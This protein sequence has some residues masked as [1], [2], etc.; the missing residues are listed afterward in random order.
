MSSWVG[1]GSCRHLFR[2]ELALGKTWFDVEMKQ[3]DPWRPTGLDDL[4]PAK[5]DERYPS[6]LRVNIAAA[7]RLTDPIQTDELVRR[8]IDI[9]WMCWIQ[10]HFENR[11][12]KSEIK[13]D[14]SSLERR[15][16]GVLAKVGS[17]E[18]DTRRV[19]KLV[20]DREPDDPGRDPPREAFEVRVEGRA[21]GGFGDVRVAEV[22]SQL[23]LLISWCQR[24]R[25]ILGPVGKGRPRQE[26][27]RQAVQQLEKIWT[28]VTGSPPTLRYNPWTKRS[29]GP[30]LDFVTL[31]LSPI[32]PEVERHI[33]WEAFVREAI[34]GE[35]PRRR[36]PN[37]SIRN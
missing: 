10:L 2:A 4:S 37:R 28:S 32:L 24:G 1:I 31:V 22:I 7:T 16:S 15:L 6:D 29:Y 9:A 12:R 3:G 34:Y 8:G 13:K 20:A 36:P 18:Y 26:A 5:F 35:K 25:E 21:F 11:P 14:L 19:L 33:G 27:R 17:L 30:F 23:E